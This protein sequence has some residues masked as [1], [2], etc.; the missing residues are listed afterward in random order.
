MDSW[1]Q[2]NFVKGSLTKCSRN[3]YF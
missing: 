1:K 2:S 3:A